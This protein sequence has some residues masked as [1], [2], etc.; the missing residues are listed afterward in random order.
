[1]LEPAGYG[2]AVSFGPKTR[3]FRTIVEALLRAD[4]AVVVANET[5]MTAF[6]RRALADV[7]FRERLG[8]AAQTLTLQNRGATRRT[9][10]TLV[11]L[12]DE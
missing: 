7:G 10:E 4:A 2:A 6:V 3:N 12:F 8:T 9:V 1:M 5:E 11:R